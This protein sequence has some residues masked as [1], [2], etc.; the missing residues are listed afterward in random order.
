M[1]TE[2]TQITDPNPEELAKAA[3]LDEEGKPEEVSPE[4]EMPEEQRQISAETKE[5]DFEEV[6]EATIID[7]YGW[8]DR[9]PSVRTL[10]DF[11]RNYRKF[12]K[13]H[14][15][16]KVDLGHAKR[17][18]AEF[19][20]S[21]LKDFADYINK[22]KQQNYVPPP[23]GQQGGGGPIPGQYGTGSEQQYAGGEYGEGQQPQQGRQ[24]TPE[25]WQMALDGIATGIKDKIGVEPLAKKIDRLERNDAWRDFRA[26]E[27][28]KPWARS[29]QVL[30]EVLEKV[31]QLA[32]EGNMYGMA[33]AYYIATNPEAITRAAQAVAE[34]DI[35]KLKIRRARG[36]SEAP[37]K[38]ARTTPQKRPGPATIDDSEE[39]IIRK[40]LEQIP[41]EEMY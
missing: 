15:N 41:P 26:T 16:L 39:E 30:E 25:Q 24:I 14:E 31:P 29:R 1:A 3:E 4:P 17:A 10:G 9:D 21:N 8:A 5:P 40:T 37:D 11:N 19:G 23:F 18:A 38:T 32:N 20:F 36:H 2:E 27:E 28:S 33:A 13:A 6:D 12:E 35:R 7:E 22:S 34:G